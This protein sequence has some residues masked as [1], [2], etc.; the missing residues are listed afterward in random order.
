MLRFQKLDQLAEFLLGG[1][2]GCRETLAYFVWLFSFAQE[3]PHMDW[4]VMCHVNAGDFLEIP[5]YRKTTHNAAVE[6]APEK[7]ENPRDLEGSKN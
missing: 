3:F 2:R 1:G 4:T 6:K 7:R 5:V